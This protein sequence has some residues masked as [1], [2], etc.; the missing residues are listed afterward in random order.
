M[1]NLYDSDIPEDVLGWLH[2]R[3]EIFAIFKR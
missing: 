2:E 3:E 1:S